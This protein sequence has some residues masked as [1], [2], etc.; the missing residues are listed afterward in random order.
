[1]VDASIPLARIDANASPG[2]RQ[3]Q[4]VAFALTSTNVVWT[5]CYVRTVDVLIRMAHSDVFVIPDII[6][7]SI[8]KIV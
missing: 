1:M 4:M 2:L 8:R 7:P 5:R 6:Y 3:P